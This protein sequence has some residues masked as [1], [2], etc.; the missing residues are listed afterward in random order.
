MP[1]RIL[2]DWTD[3]EPVDNLSFQAEVLLTRLIMK[4]DD[5]GSYHANPKLLNAFCFPLKNIRETDITRWLQELA[6][7]GLIVLYDAENK[8]FLNIL[9]FNQ[10]LRSMKRCFP[11]IPENVIIENCQQVAGKSLASC[12]PE[13]EVEV[14][15]ETEGEGE[16]K[17]APTQ[18][19]ESIENLFPEEKKDEL[20]EQVNTGSEEKEKSSAK[21]EKEIIDCFHENCSGLPKVQ[22]LTKLRK[23]SINARISDYG[24]EKVKEVIKL[25]G[26]SKFLAG[27]NRNEWTADFDW[28]LKPTNFVKILEGNYKDKDINNGKSNNQTGA[29]GNNTPAQQATYNIQEAAGRLAEDFAKGNIPGVYR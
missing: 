8:P 27:N 9:N 6:S 15:V 5:F 25:A 19:F 1:Q 29:T 20:S 13:E 2:R 17:G 23:K 28:I 16:K 3:S 7:S 10:R 14:E 12:Q 4:A 18:N 11:Q 24:I 26:E 21:K 22:I